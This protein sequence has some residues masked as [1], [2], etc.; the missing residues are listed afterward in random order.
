MEELRKE[1]ARLLSSLAFLLRCRDEETIPTFARVRAS[2]SSPAI[3]RILR[4]TSLALV[5]ERIHDKRKSLDD[6]ARK[7]LKIHLCLSSSL[8]PL[9]WEYVDRA[10][11]AMGELLLIKD[12]ERQRK[13]YSRLPSAKKTIT[14]PD[15]KRVVI[16][17]TN[18]TLDE[19]TLTVLAKGLNFAPAPGAIPYRDFIGGLEP[20]IRKLP[21][22]LAEEV[23]AEVTM[24]LK[25]AVPPKP[26]TT[27]QERSALR[28]LRNDQEVTILPA[29]KGNATVL[30][31]TEDYRRKITDIL[32][33]QA[34]RKLP[35]DPTDA[36]TRKTLTLIKNSGLSEDVT[37]GLRPPAPAPP[38]LYGLPKIHKEN[39]PL[40]PIV[41]A[42]G[43]PT[44][45][46]AKFLARVLSQHVG[47]CEH[48]IKN[49]SEFVK[50]LADIRLEPN[51]II[52]SFDVVSLFTRVPLMDTLKLLDARFDKDTVNLFHHVLTSTYF[53]YDGQ[54]FE[55][56][57]GVAMGSPLSPVIANFYMEDFEE[58]ALSSAPL[59]PKCFFRYVDDTFIIWP[60]GPDQLKHFLDHMNSQ[61][62]NILFTMEVEKNGRLPFLDI[63]IYRRE[64]GRLGHSVYR[65][66]THTDLYL[67]GRSHHPP[68]QRRSVLSTLF[69]RAR[70]ISDSDCLAQEINHLKKTFRQNGYNKGE[71]SSALRRA[72]S[73]RESARED[74]ERQEPEARAGIPYVSTV[75]GKISRILKRH[76]IESFFRPCTKLRDQ[77]V[78]AKDPCGLATPGIY[79]IP[80]EC[81]EVYLGETGRTIAT[82][83]KE[84]RRHFR[85]CQPE[86]SAVA[87]HG[88]HQNHAIHW[89]DVK[90]ISREKKYWERITKEAIEIRLTDRHFNRDGGYSLSNIWKPVL[91]KI[92]LANTK[93]QSEGT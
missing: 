62:P 77:L 89:E 7:L 43:S 54:F 2:V 47:H 55:Q 72:F 64:N 50:I 78:R 73:D 59:R 35:R 49:S 12:T 19:P 22:D 26:N 13:K 33:D 17:L 16:N 80:C 61:H 15:S 86:K 81:G 93:D 70:A 25:R 39:V 32:Q 30:M 91:D 42:I 88:I 44:Y 92:R 5:R 37:R 51:D 23:R 34:Y 65:K 8:S 52:V 69:H 46:L 90:I 28:A 68:S 79:Q 67:N 40:R 63:L 31:S 10:T 84:H 11:A 60:H 14:A 53:K 3:Q 29:D 20:A 27:R 83:I 82:R 87:E 18:R 75:S 41:S 38:R 9:D 1:K 45:E 6:N 66:P 57:D 85:L 21:A 56:R 74:E 71:I 36:I 58:K 4:R 48:H 76:G 24:A